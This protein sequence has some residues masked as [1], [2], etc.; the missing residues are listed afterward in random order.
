MYSKI[1][2]LEVQEGQAPC[3]KG[4][5]PI[6]KKKFKII[7]SLEGSKDNLKTVAEEKHGAA[8]LDATGGDSN[9]SWQ[10]GRLSIH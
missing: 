10:K 3:P 7:K 4:N 2:A 6:K 8:H 1:G 5:G 9:A